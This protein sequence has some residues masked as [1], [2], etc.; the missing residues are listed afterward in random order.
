MDKLVF[1]DDLIFDDGTKGAIVRFTRTFDSVPGLDGVAYEKPTGVQYGPTEDTNAHVTWGFG[2]TKNKDTA[3][4][5]GGWVLGNVGGG[6]NADSAVTLTFDLE[7]AQRARLRFHYAT[8][9]DMPKLN[10]SVN[11]VDHNTIN[12]PRTGGKS[13][14]SE[15]EFTPR[16]FR[17]GTNTIVLGGSGAAS[18]SQ[19]GGSIRLN[20]IEVI[21]LDEDE[22]TGLEVRRSGSHV[23]A[24]N[25]NAK[26]T[27]AIWTKLI[28]AI[29]DDQ[30]RLAHVGAEDV[31]VDPKRSKT[32]VFDVDLN[33]FEDCAVETFAW[34]PATYVPYQDCDFTEITMHD[35]YEL[36]YTPNASK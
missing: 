5:N 18:S 17:A 10:L 15:L 28:F 23:S 22:P 7:K 14:F 4:G 12:F 30:G 35:E 27:A 34:D 26:D 11:G 20:Y 19:V 9:S 29:Y 13:F 8:T 2:V 25:Y 3:A 24:I 33:E 32:A 36:G 21:P 31:T 16:K 6:A 1:D